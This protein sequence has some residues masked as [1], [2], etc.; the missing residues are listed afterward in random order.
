MNLAKCINVHIKGTIIIKLDSIIMS[1][2]IYMY[3]RFILHVNYGQTS[4]VNETASEQ[5]FL[6]NICNYSSVISSRIVLFNS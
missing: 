1:K 3:V 2:Q 4:Q 5:A 6:V